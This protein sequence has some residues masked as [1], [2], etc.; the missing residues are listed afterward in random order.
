MPFMQ[1]T[2]ADTGPGRREARRPPPAPTPSA[3]RRA[4]RRLG[5][6]QDARF[7]QG[8]FKTAPGEY[9]A[10]DRFRG[11][12]V[13]VLRRL[14]RQFAAL[15]MPA[16]LRLLGSPWHE[17]RLLALLLLVRRFERGTVP[18]RDRI[19]AAYLRHTRHVNN[20]DLVDLSAPNIVGAWLLRRDASLL[21]RLAGSGSLW[22]RRIAVVATLAFLRAGR[23]QPT[24]A[25]ARRLLADR[26]DLIHKATGWMLREAGK[27][28]PAALRRFLARHA[29]RMPRTMLRYAI[30]R[31]PAAERRRWLRAGL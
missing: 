26:E 3:V 25:I 28:E 7:L 13:P 29:A 24:F 2:H 9:G 27:R 18:E 5:D 21:D 6:F 1:R 14:A 17:D 31:L 22:E 10:G 23:L 16:V 15:P 4:L 12:R 11:I 19:A 30:E 8:F 20:W